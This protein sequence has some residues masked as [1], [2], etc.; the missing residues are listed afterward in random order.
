MAA[1]I[2]K[3][4]IV[5]LLTGRWDSDEPARGR[6]LEVYPKEGKVLVE[7]FNLQKRHLKAGSRTDV[8]ESKILERPGKIDI[9]NVRFYSEKL[10]RGVRVG[11]E[12]TGKNKIRV[13]RGKDVSGTPLD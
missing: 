6:V 13:A 2:K 7:G 1:K 9:S 8:Q 3:G 11:F 10:G 12:G 4:D 5:E